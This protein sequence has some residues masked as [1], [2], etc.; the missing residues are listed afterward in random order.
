MWSHLSFIFFR[1]N[2]SKKKMKIFK[3]VRI[4]VKLEKT[5]PKQFI[6]IFFTCF[7][8]NSWSMDIYNC[9]K[10]IL[11]I[12]SYIIHNN[13]QYNC[14]TVI[15]HTIK[16]EWNILSYLKLLFSHY[17]IDMWI[18]FLAICITINLRFLYAVTFNSMDC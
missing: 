9:N 17:R 18:F 11:Y 15:Y 7:V 13:I 2:I 5:K 8:R 12:S 10:K 6:F 3:N 14:A 4:H 16:N 1:Y